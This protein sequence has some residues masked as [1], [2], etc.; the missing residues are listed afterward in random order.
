VTPLHL[1]LP[2]DIDDPRRPSGGNIYD[3]RVGDGL[4]GLGH[5][6][7][8]HPVRGPWPDLDAGSCRALAATLD[9]LPD[10]ALVVVDGLVGS[11]AGV[12]AANARRLR[13]VVLVHLPLGVG[14]REREGLAAAVAVLATSRWTARWLLEHYR[15]DERRLHVATP[16]VDSAPPAVASP[17]GERLLCVGAVTPVKGQDLLVEALH[18][19]RDL[20][21]RARLVGSTQVDPGYS[22]GVR[23][24]ADLLGLGDRVR[25]TGPLTGERLAA[26][27]AGADLLLAPS[28]QESFGMAIVEAL[29]R[30]MP[31][32]AADVGGVAEALGRGPDGALPGVLL[33][34]HDVPAWTAAL[35]EWL[36]E[37]DRRRAL[38]DAAASRRGQLR[39]WDDTVRLVSRVL[40]RVGREEVA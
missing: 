16:G 5:P 39:S 32:L 37:P 33:D 9:G 40:E 1:V 17:A 7:R 20:A 14:S 22:A 21:C 8:E 19:V 35:R 28:R 23:Q 4:R 6:V 11:A 2:N 3:R 38:R 18:G 25:L 30:G 24:R 26:A 15:L 29:A 13:L 34:P 27:Y 31:V 12:L 10:G 36:T